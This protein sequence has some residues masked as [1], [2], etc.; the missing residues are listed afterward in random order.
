MPASGNTIT[1]RK[2]ATTSTSG[3]ELGGTYSTTTTN[4]SGTFNTIVDMLAGDSISLW[5]GTT[6]QAS[7][8]FNYSPSTNF[9]GYLISA[10]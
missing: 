8:T 9:V 10:V 4:I 2:N 3:I 1:I 5:T 6:T 7:F